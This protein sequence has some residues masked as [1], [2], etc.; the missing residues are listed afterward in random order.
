MIKRYIGIDIERSC[1]SAVQ[2]SSDR[3]QFTIE[4][5]FNEQIGEAEDSIPNILRTLVDKHGFDRRAAIA[6]TLADDAVF[7][8]SLEVGSVD[9]KQVDLVS[10]AALQHSFP[11]QPDNIVA[12]VCPNC[13][14]DGEKTSVLM[15]AAKKKSL[16]DT[17]DTLKIANIHPIRVQA[18]IFAVHST[19]NCN[20]PESAAGRVIIAYINDS[21][22]TLAITQDNH[23]LMVRNI[24]LVSSYNDNSP[25]HRQEVV[26]VMISEANITWQKVF[27]EKI[28]GDTRI[29]L[30][31]GSNAP[32]NM[33]AAIIEALNC[34]IVAVN[35]YAMAKA[36]PQPNDLANICI[37]EGLALAMS[38]PEKAAG[39][40]F[41]EVEKNSI[42]PTVNMKKEIAIYATLIAAIAV[43]SIGGLFWHLSRL[44]SEYAMVK[45]K[46]NE[47]FKQTLPQESNIV[48]P[49][50]QLDQK[51]LS[52]RKS[53]TLFA[54]ASKARLTTLGV[55]H[56]ISASVP[57]QANIDTIL[58]TAESARITGVCSSFELV[59]SWQKQLENDQAFTDIDVQNI[60]MNNQTKMVDFTMA[61]SLATGET[62]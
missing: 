41:L 17:L 6:T 35:P 11:L 61:I 42:K 38:S 26:N 15:A 8:R 27:D 40:N 21:N 46:I 59:Y 23:I 36:S 10:Q 34:R 14:S 33:E 2:I 58:I 60:K 22:L 20:H 5:T 47:I 18:K 3:R 30:A 52:I 54:P 39:I 37:A 57:S 43:I 9:N 29:Y 56:A 55:F 4:K 24:P 44:E 7:F 31:K 50:A 49:L 16:Y 28:N 32:D 25:E 48:N 45:N 1:L 62:Q 19:V 53:Y 12:Q 51:L 13:R